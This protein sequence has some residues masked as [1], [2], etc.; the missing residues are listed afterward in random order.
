MY[1]RLAG[2]ALII[3][4]LVHVTRQIKP[5]RFGLVFGLLL[6]YIPLHYKIPLNALPLI[7]ALTVGL[8]LL[9]ALRPGD[10]GPLQRHATSFRTL[11]VAFCGLSVLGLAIAAS[12]E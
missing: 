3:W 8:A 1:I 5:T 10:G 9:I 7:N 6:F 4:L 12:H 11:A 2:L